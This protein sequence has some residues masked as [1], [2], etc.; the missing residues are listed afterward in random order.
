MLAKVISD[1]PNVK[2]SSDGQSDF[3]TQI[4]SGGTVIPISSVRAGIRL[5]K[6]D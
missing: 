6:L 4:G 1:I 5:R 2:L 3:E